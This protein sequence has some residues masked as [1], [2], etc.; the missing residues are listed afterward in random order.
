[1]KPY[2]SLMFHN[3]LMLVQISRSQIKIV[4]LS[5]P[6]HNKAEPTFNKQ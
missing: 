5:Q 6:E 3:F 4:K 1:M 2:K